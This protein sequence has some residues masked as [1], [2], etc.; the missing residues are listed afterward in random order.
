M[1]CYLGVIVMQWGVLGV[2]LATNITAMSNM[3]VQD[4]WISL[5]AEE[6]RFKDMWIAWARTSSD[7]LW[8]FLDCALW[9][10]VL[11]CSHWWSLELLLLVSGFNLLGG[12]EDLSKTF[13]AQVL[14]LNFY[15][16]AYLVPTG[17][18]TAI[19]SHVG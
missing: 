14:L 10:I 1:A 12:T 2:A 9:N 5:E 15:S 19:S 4:L 8:R 16:L 11:E 3:I 13:S 17:L 18:S 6:G 7:G